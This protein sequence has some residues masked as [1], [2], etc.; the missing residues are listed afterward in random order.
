MSQRQSCPHVAPKNQGTTARDTASWQ[1]GE[2]WS[3]TSIRAVVASSHR[4]CILAARDVISAAVGAVASSLYQRI[5]LS[6]LSKYV[7]IA[8]ELA[9]KLYPTMQDLI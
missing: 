3:L 1:R 9:I 6:V 5:V 8:Q 4:D 2:S 7:E